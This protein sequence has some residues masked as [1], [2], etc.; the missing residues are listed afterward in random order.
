M[1][2]S[3]QNHSLKKDEILRSPKAIQRLFAEGDSLFSFP[4][5]LMISRLEDIEC[6]KSL[7]VSFSVPKRNH[8]KAATR[9][10][11]KRRMKECYRKNKPDLP[12]QD[13]G[14]YALMYIL[15]DKSVSDYEL[16]LIHI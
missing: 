13:S 3:K 7:L 11:L 2:D 5:K 1:K 6:K 12:P 14:G 16:S 10:L 15:V 8:K 4:Y 9:N